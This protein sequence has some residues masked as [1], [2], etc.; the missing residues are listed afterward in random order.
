MPI[1]KVAIKSILG[2]VENYHLSFLADVIGPSVLEKK[3]LER[4][5]KKGLVPKGTDLIQKAYEYGVATGGGSKLESS[6]M[7]LADFGKYSKIAPILTYEERLAVEHAKDNAATYVRALGTQLIKK[8]RAVILDA[9]KKLRRAKLL[10]KSVNEKQILKDVSK[11][12]KQILEAQK[13]DL[14]KIAVTEVNNALQEGR[15]H[16]IVKSSGPESDPYV[17]KRPQPDACKYCK[18]LYL[19]KSGVPK[20]FRLSELVDNGSNVG[21]KA[22][23]PLAKCC[24]WRATVDSIHPHCR[25]ELHHMPPGFGFNDKGTMVYKGLKKK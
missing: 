8:A 24:G 10:K 15:M 13:K 2:M 18:L 22:G 20:V 19:T 3:E 25:C 9:D 6:G 11:S 7:S 1:S 17:F 14:L 23:R 12:I 4:L 5:T 16:A 21:R